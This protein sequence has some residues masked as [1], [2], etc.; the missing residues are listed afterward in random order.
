MPISS[1]T[2]GSDPAEDWSALNA[3]SSDALI[4]CRSQINRVVVAKIIERSGIKAHSAAPEDAARLLGAL[5]PGLVIL[6]GG[7]DNRDCDVLMAS[8]VDQRRI[9]DGSGP[10]VILL[11]TRTGT[12]TGIT[13]G[14]PVDAVV[15]KPITPESLQPVVDRLMSRARG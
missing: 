9:G 1:L 3:R 7:A 15:A 2:P 4:V 6:D 10:S 5:K 12:P 8:L 14:S 11:S 13:I